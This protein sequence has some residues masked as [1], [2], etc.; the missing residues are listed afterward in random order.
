MI[1]KLKTQEYAHA[2]EQGSNTRSESVE[3]YIGQKDKYG[4]LDRT[5]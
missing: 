4:D 1:N 5:A 3:I 2:K